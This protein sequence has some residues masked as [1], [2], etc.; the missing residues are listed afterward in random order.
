MHRHSIFIM[1]AL[2]PALLLS[3]CAQVDPRD[4]YRRVDKHVE[5]AIG[6]LPPE[7][8]ADRAATQALVAARLEGGCTVDEAVQISMLNNPTVRSALLGVGIGRADLVQA[9]L[10]QNPSLALSMRLPDGGGLTNLEFSLAQN[11]ADLWLTPVRRQAA[12]VE[13]DRAIL[14]A[15]RTISGVALD[16]RTAY[17]GAIAAD[18]ELEIAGSSVDIARQLLDAAEER[19]RAGVGSAIDVSLARAEYM[20]AELAQRTGKLAAF[21]ARRSLTVLLGL[22]TPPDDLVLTDRLPDPPTWTL[23]PESLVLAAESNRL[24]L[25]ASASLVDAAAARVRQEELSVVTDIEV[26]V[27]FEREQRGQRGDRPWLA[28]T[29][30]SSADAG[31]LT[32]PSLRP[33]E[34]LPTDTILGPSLGLKLPIWDQNQAQIARARYLHEQAAAERD[35]LL[36]DAT[37]ETRAACQRARTAWDVSAYYRDKYLPLLESNLEL[38]RDAY[39]SGKVPVFTVLE[40]QKSLIS[41]RG[42]SVR[43]LRDASVSLTDLERSV[44]APLNRLLALPGA[45][46]QPVQPN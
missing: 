6:Q 14:Y 9:G 45:T 18:R 31:A 39:R 29:L 21:E 22:K 2:T 34:K 4:D 40:A 24:D 10:F 17:F 42:G 35:A 27:A 25:R 23:T 1:R 20:Q 44:G 15:A 3:G 43:A 13:L 19:Q 12:S 38:S 32:A 7:R 5:A 37:Q 33:R 8:S 46:T 16:V 26:G 30:W 41:A 28:D 11:V 36:I